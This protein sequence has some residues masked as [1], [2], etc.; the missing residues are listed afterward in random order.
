MQQTWLTPLNH[1]HTIW[2]AYSGGLD[3]SVLLHLIAQ[4]RPALHRPLQVVYINHGLSP[5]A[6]AWQE[7]CQQTCIRLALPYQ[8]FT[9]SAQPGQGESPEAA[10]RNARYQAFKRCMQYNDILLTAHHQDDQVETLLLQLLRGAGVKGLAAM[11]EISGLGQGHLLRPLLKFTRAQLLDYAQQQNVVWIEDESNFHDR[12]ARNYLRHQLL[13][14]IQQRWSSAS[15]TITRTAQHCAEAAVLIDELAAID[16][17]ALIGD[18]PHILLIAKL[19]T[20]SAARQRNVIR[21]WLTGLGFPIP[22]TQHMQQILQT[23]LHCASDAEPKVT[24][25][26][27]E[28]RRYREYLYAL[29]VQVA[30]QGYEYEWDPKQPLTLSPSSVTLTCELKQGQGIKQHYL[31]KPLL[32]R[33][34]RGGERCHPQG[35]LGSH[36]LKKCMQ[37]WGIPP[38]QRAHIPLIYAG[39][40]LLAVV[41]YCICEPYVAAADEVGGVFTL[42]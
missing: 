30:L 8:S 26:S 24:W 32:V 12:F 42:S 7:H 18:A 9:V 35:R 38:W 37:E 20:L 3:S 4:L 11:P 28:I 23:V 31:T 29:P 1:S 5:N 14:I 17:T 2:I 13:P 22:N 33:F 34:R 6:K 16:S 21:Y 36:P 15:K 27:V 10:A 39:E 19:Q 41:G 40:H 25:D